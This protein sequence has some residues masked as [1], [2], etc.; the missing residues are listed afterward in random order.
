ML[1]LPK[2]KKSARRALSRVEKAHKVVVGVALAL[3]VTLAGLPASDANASAAPMQ[4]AQVV[5]PTSGA[6]LLSAPA[7][8][9][10]VLADHFSHSSHASHASHASHHSHFSSSY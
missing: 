8:A 5:Q 6:M 9:R 2:V 4:A 10:E 7:P 1:S 3:G